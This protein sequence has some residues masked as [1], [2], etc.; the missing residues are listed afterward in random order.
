MDFLKGEGSTRT[1]ADIPMAWL[2]TSGGLTP[3]D[4][5]RLRQAREHFIEANAD[6]FGQVGKDFIVK[7]TGKAYRIVLSD[8][9]TSDDPKDSGIEV[10]FV[11]W[12]Q[13]LAYLKPLGSEGRTRSVPVGNLGG[14]R[15]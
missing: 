10:F 12:D 15:V 6:D 4:E 13:R 2:P 1:A 5:W 8:P 9:T 14:G 11:T 3:A 7:V